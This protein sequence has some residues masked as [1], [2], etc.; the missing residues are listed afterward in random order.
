[1]RRILIFILAALIA[2]SLFG[3]GSKTEKHLIQKPERRED[4]ARETETETETETEQ[5]EVDWSYSLRI[6]QTG[7]EY[8][9][10]DGVHLAS[11]SYER[12]VLEVV[13]DVDFYGATP[14]DEMQEVCDRFN[15]KLDDIYPDPYS[16]PEICESARNLYDQMDEN[17][18]VSF[19]TFIEEVTVKNYRIDGDLAEFV[20]ERYGYR[21]GA[22]GGA[23][24]VGYHFD[25]KNGE[26]FTLSDV[27]DD[28]DALNA[29]V[30]E[31]I[32]IQVY[33][34][35]EDNYYLS[36][37]YA[38]TINGY[39]DFNVS[40]GD[41]SLTVIFGEYEIGPYAAGIIEFEIPYGIVSRF[42]NEDGERLLSPSLESK[43][44]GR[45]YDAN[46]M[47][48]WFEGVIPYDFNDTKTVKV[49]DIDCVYY[50][51]EIPG[52][53]SVEDLREKMLTRMTA[54]VVDSRISSFQNDP[55]YPMFLEEGG[56]LY[57]LPMG[58]GGDMSINSIDY[59]V[60]LFSSG[61]GGNVIATIV[62]QDYDEGQG[63]WVLTGETTDVAFPFTFVDGE[64]VFTGFK[65][66]W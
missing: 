60:E 58:R 16:V 64:A 32:I 50:R 6:D 61:N 42:L 66:L 21:G 53:D 48:Y 65:T 9:S 12:P 33:K 3:C 45:Y 2:A 51:V 52:V 24:R 1:M 36:P 49:G 59:R 25:L 47:W 28:I 56:A 31:E 54:D 34:N 20:I 41:D 23:T 18:R 14:P 46:E 7:S 38:D 35:G 57:V 63:D 40:L 4:T 62:W 29:A 39:K 13:S 11:V 8:E 10:E 26:Y 5:I 22:H 27:T 55:D 15:E 37:G 43:I 19:H 17:A 30:A 44:L